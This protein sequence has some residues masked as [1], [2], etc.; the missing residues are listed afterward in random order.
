MAIF[1][2][3]NCTV[4]PDVPVASDGGVAGRGVIL[5]AI[6]TAG[7]S[8]VLSMS[9]I[10]HEMYD[11]PSRIRRKLLNSYS[12]QQLLISIGIS[13]VGLAKVHEM[14]PYHFFIIWMLTNMSLA[15]HNATL[16]ALA[17]DFRR[18]W[19]LRWLRQIL[20]L[21]SLSLNTT[22]GVFILQGVSSNMQESKLPVACVWIVGDAGKG[23]QTGLSY[24]GTISVIAANII[25]FILA[26]WYLHH[27]GFRRTRLSRAFQVVGTLI[28]MA[29][30]IGAATRV[31]IA[32]DAWGNGPAYELQ[33]DGEKRWGFGQLLSMLVL[34]FPLVSM[35]EII[36]GEIGVKECDLSSNTGSDTEMGNYRG[37]LNSSSQGLVFFGVQNNSFK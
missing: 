7:V 37:S 30:A 16:L 26:S 34:I 36:R 28:M 14:V 3:A 19:V 15:V 20:M 33:D 35:T 21:L 1:E 11:N 27:K 4:G 22:Y 9:I 12:D 29:S 17:R 32:S 31:I 23:S 5:A 8:L 10:V 18:D 25:V 2:P 13:C 6:I 24:F